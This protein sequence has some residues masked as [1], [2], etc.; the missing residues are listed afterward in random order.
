MS[1]TEQKALYADRNPCKLEPHYTA[2]VMA[3]TREDLHSKSDIA[4]ELAWRDQEIEALRAQVEALTIENQA[5]WT[6][7]STLQSQRDAFLEAG[8]RA[9]YLLVRDRDAAD[10][11][12]TGTDGE[13]DAD[14]AR[15]VAEFNAVIAYIDSAVEGGKKVQPTPSP[16]TRPAVPE[17]WKLVPV[18]PP[19]S[20]AKAG[21][22]YA[23]CGLQANAVFGYRAMLAAAPQPEAQ[24]TEVGVAIPGWTESDAL[25]ILNR[26]SDGPF[27]QADVD[28]ALEF[29]RHVDDQRQMKILA[30]VDEAQPTEAAQKGGA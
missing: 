25:A 29:M 7:R 27:G 24:P 22:Q 10:E 13:I 16:L 9:R 4:A 30:A 2:H 19:D 3:M 15:A 21:A 17:G 28:D 1:T 12:H 26:I 11:A 8:L 5:L 14:G 20:M 18:E 6:D 23:E